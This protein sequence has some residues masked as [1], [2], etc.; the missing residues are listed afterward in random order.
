MLGHTL[1]PSS[2]L[3][4]VHTLHGFCIH[5]PHTLDT[6]GHLRINSC[7]MCINKR[8]LS[9]ITS[10]SYTCTVFVSCSFHWP[11]SLW[12]DCCVCCLLGLP[13]MSEG[14]N[15]DTVPVNLETGLLSVVRK[16]INLL[17]DSH[18]R[19]VIGPILDQE[20][21]VV[22]ANNPS[23]LIRTA[24]VRV[25]KP[26]LARIPVTYIDKGRNGR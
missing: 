16:I 26:F 7:Y 5:T 2:L 20:S 4:L 25:S 18:V 13:A 8:G 17:P 3:S 14:G 19:K 22:M 15:S 12:S 21:I 24:V 11:M 10:Y 1:A 9:R 23:I 6:F